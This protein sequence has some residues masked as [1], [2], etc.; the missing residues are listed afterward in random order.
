MHIYQA[1]TN[2]FM[3][4]S[5]REFDSEGNL[6]D[7]HT[8]EFTNGYSYPNFSGGILIV[9]DPKLIKLLDENPRN[10]KN[11]G[12][13]WKLKEV[14]QENKPETNNPLQTTV[15]NESEVIVNQPVKDSEVKEYPEITT[16]PAAVSKL[17]EL[18]PSIKTADVR[19]KAQI[20]EAAALLNISFPNL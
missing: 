10:V 13:E 18:E 2:I 8:V 3:K 1:I 9:N 12:S 20:R 14:I 16:N 7:V 17:R 19:N 4:V 11:G 15:V 6:V 5:L